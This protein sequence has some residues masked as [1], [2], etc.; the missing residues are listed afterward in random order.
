MGW[1]VE[2]E[3]RGGNQGIG[4]NTEGVGWPLKKT[5]ETPCFRDEMCQPPNSGIDQTSCATLH[6]LSPASVP[7]YRGAPKGRGI[8]DP[9]LA[10][11][12]KQIP[13]IRCLTFGGETSRGT[14][15]MHGIA[16]AASE[17]CSKLCCLSLWH[18][19]ASF[20]PSQT[21]YS[22]KLER[23]IQESSATPQ[24][25]SRKLTGHCFKL[26]SETLAQAPVA[27]LSPNSLS[28]SPRYTN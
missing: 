18:K 10:F 25:T 24:T 6:F 3:T 19:S 27:S 13:S 20:L 12:A 15:L 22:R 8:I 21:W 5:R 17:T 2:K 4:R 23:G 11:S 9:S 26:S 16:S 7:L 14:S 28:P 1:D